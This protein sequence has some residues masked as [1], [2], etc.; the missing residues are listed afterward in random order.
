MYFKDIVIEKDSDRAILRLNRPEKLNAYNSSMENEMVN[1]VAD[2][3][4]DDNIKVVI[5]TGT[6]RG[7]C[8]GHDLAEV[9]EH[10]KEYTGTNLP[11]RFDLKGYPPGI[12]RNITKP[13]IAAVNGIAAGGGLAL[14]LSCDLRI[15]SESAVFY[16]NHVPRVGILPG[17]ELLMLPRLIGI[18]KALELIFTGRKIDAKEAQSIGLIGRVVSADQLMQSA[19]ELARE[20]AKSPLLAL[21]HAK[22]VAYMGLGLP[23]DEAMSYVTLSRIV[24]TLSNTL[25]LQRPKE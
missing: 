9:M 6:G 4:A 19:D 22:K 23:V 10:A 8:S 16:E 5:I 7:F 25:A 20:I 15:A 11:L 24:T 2:I 18:E 21:R 12:I 13:T 1:A 17:L 14:A 3:E